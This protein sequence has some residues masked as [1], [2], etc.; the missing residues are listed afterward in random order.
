MAPNRHRSLFR[1]RHLCILSY[2][3]NSKACRS[4]KDVLYIERLLCYRRCLFSV[5]E[6][7]VKYY[8]RVMAPNT[9]RSLFPIRH[10]ACAYILTLITRKL[11]V[12]YGHSLHRTTALL[13]KIFVVWFRVAWEIRL[14]SS[15][16]RH[17]SRS[18]SDTTL[19]VYTA[20]TYIH[21]SLFS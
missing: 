3:H 2:M 18:F 19:C 11:Q 20:S 17:E 21:T 7:H 9:H 6:L 8:F 12:V 13:S 10:L 16:P 5:L 4:Y 15:V 1:I 14:E